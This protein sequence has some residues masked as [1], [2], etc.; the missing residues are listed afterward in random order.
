MAELLEQ[1][2]ISEM[3]NRVDNLQEIFDIDKRSL[4]AELEALSTQENFWNDSNNAQVL[5]K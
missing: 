2:V 5:K 4:V 3:K 1:S